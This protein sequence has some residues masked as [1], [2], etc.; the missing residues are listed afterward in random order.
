MADAAPL[1]A[2][3]GLI[4]VGQAAR[5]LMITTQWI[6]QLAKDGYCPA[7]MRGMVNTVAVIQGY[8]KSL[9]DEERRSSKSASASRVQDARAT[10]IE[11]RVARERNKLVDVDEYDAVFDEAFGVV[12]A[13][14][15]GLP[16]RVSRDIDFR[17]KLEAEIDDIFREAFDYFHA[18]SAAIR[19]TGE[20]PAPVEA[21]DT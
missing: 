11:L 12:K 2:Q 21:D 8:I 15:A 10:E 1:P 17:Q 9:K 19:E 16:A 6:R 7:P 3:G 18:A 13:S 5:L 14:F 20:A 4:P